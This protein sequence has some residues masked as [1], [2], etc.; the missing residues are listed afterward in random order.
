MADRRAAEAKPARRATMTVATT[1]PL[2]R[3]RA[4][5]NTLP[6]RGTDTDMQKEIKSA[7]DIQ[8]EINAQ[9]AAAG[10]DDTYRVGMP[11]RLDPPTPDGHNWHFLDVL[12]GDIE[13][14]TIATRILS[15]ARNRYILP[16]G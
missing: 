7:R 5:D 8:Q 2:Q 3:R 12:T 14:M 6:T 15:D 11:A 1:M 16:E 4:T 13:K 9:L 10:F